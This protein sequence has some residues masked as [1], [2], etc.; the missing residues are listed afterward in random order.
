MNKDFPEIRDFFGAYFHQDWPVEHDTADQ[1]IDEFLDASNNEILIQTSHEL[2]TLLSKDLSETEL[3]AYLL[4]ELKCYY[5]YWN[6]W[7]SGKAWLCVIE[8]KLNRKLAGR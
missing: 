8:G 1:V 3:R 4:K 6:E 2:K 7:I 5:C